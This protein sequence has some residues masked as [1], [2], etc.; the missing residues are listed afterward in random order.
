MQAYIIRYG[1]IFLKGKN[2]ASF[3]KRLANN[4][5]D[6]LRKSKIQ[7]QE[8][9]IARNRILVYSNKD[10]CCLKNVFGISSF[11]KALEMEQDLEA[12]KKTALALYK[13]GSFRIT[14]Q[15]LEKDFKHNSNEI[16]QIVGA[17]VV[18]NKKAKVDL[19]NPETNIGIELFNKK[20]YLFNAKMRGL[21]GLPV[22][23]EGKVA[24]LLED[25]NSMLSAF[26]MLKRG[27]SIVLI[28]K[29]KVD[30]KELKKFCC[31]FDLEVKKS[32]PKGTKAIA[33][34]DTLENIKPRKFKCTVFRPLVGYSK[35]E[36]EKLERL[37]KNG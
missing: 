15:R 36:L 5:I 25:K 7:F 29:S 34:N 1:E 37:L 31:G 30:C 24:V 19:E 11:S 27:C 2:R 3:E 28:E 8:V 16:N 12:F 32:I 18:K 10:C 14:A 35:A 22:G 4:I 33:V 13:P 9:K 17:Y 26:L 6:C 23:I 21:N 20:A